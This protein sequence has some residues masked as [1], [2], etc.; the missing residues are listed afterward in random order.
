ME[1]KK[2]RDE[3]VTKEEKA[4]EA[5]RA[6][7]REYA[8]KN[9]EKLREYRKKWEKENPEKVKSYQLNYWSKKGTAAAS[10]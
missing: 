5:R 7:A 8:K 2:M 1:L 10:E 9:R 4:R 3:E 6:Y